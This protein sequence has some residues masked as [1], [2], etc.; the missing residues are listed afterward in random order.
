MKIVKGLASLVLLLVLVIGIPAVLVLIVGNPLPSGETLQN[1]LTTPDYGGRF[2]FGSFL[3]IVAWIAWLTFAASVIVEIPSAVGGI[4]AP[5]IK[6]LGAQQ[7]L[8]GALIGAILLMFT[9]GSLISA[10]KAQATAP[11][12]SATQISAP[13]S[14]E[15]NTQ[16][17]APA[18]NQAPEQTKA[19]PK[20]TVVAG[21]SLWLLAETYLGDGA[22]YGEIAELNYGVAQADGG[23]LSDGHWIEPGWVL[24]LPASAQAVEKQAMTHVVAEGESLSSIAEH[25]Y[26]DAG[27]FEQ[28]F[29][30]SQGVAQP[31]GGSLTDPDVVLPGWV[32]TVPAAAVVAPTSLA[33]AAT[34]PAV[35]AEVPPP[36]AAPAPAVEAPT[37]PAPAVETPA[38]TAPS[39]EAPAPAVEPTPAAASPIPGASLSNVPVA[40]DEAET[41]EETPVDSAAEAEFPVRTIGG[42]GALLASGLLSV[43]G[44]RRIAQRRRRRA[45][46]RVAAPSREDENLELQLRAVEEPKTIDDLDRAL[47]FLAVWGQDNSIALPQMFC[48]RVAADEIAI[49]LAAPAQLPSPFVAVDDSNTVWTIEPATIGDLDREPTAPYPALVTVGQDAKDAHLLIDLEYVGALGIAG[50]E[51]LVSNALTALAVELA[52]SKWGEQLQVTMVGVSDELPAALSTGKV[53]HVDDMDALLVLLR[54]KAK[55]TKEAFARLGVSGVEEARTLGRDAEGWMPEIVILGQQPSASQRTELEELVTAIPRIGIAAVSAGKVTGDWEIRIGSKG[56]ATLEPLGL[57]MVPQLITDEE[58]K[59]IMS[60]LSVA[61]QD[62]QP[63]PDW[64][65]SSTQDDIAVEDVPVAAAEAA[66]EERKLYALPPEDAPAAEPVPEVQEE[67]PVPSELVALIDQID[68]AVEG[69][70]APIIAVLGTVSIINPQGEAPRTPGS[71]SVSAAAVAR[72]TALAAFLALNPGA[73]METYHEAFWPT[74]DPNGKTA[75]SNRNKLSNLTRNYL[76]QRATDGEMYFPHVGP[77]DGY[78]LHP[79]VTT[80][81]RVFLDLIGEDL[82]RTSTPRLVAALRLVRGRPFSGVKDQLYTWS[83]HVIDGMLSGICDAAHELARR[84]L[85]TGDTANARLAGSVGRIVDPANEQMWRDAILAEHAAGNSAG[86][87]ELVSKLHTY[88]DGFNEDYEPDEETQE[89]IKELRRHGHPIAS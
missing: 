58:G 67:E 80:D 29:K 76:G 37:A 27:A 77:A 4:R 65:A 52:T 5:R 60:L 15:A 64:A 55:A 61:S 2:L 24:N 75:S 71:G 66:Q 36:A 56:S 49:Y 53:R 8:A 19:L 86:V 9:A 51:E 78:K 18:L 39:V 72:C 41:V 21:E 46:E 62:C 89:L 43:L 44:L 11:E 10:P 73:S 20:H 16:N 47:K 79:D 28:I 1:L 70:G 74:A 6:G 82:A 63:G 83:E 34:P 85:T 7:A 59:K 50:E 48:V 30:A 35:A 69:D 33:Q 32:L 3:P 14:V 40:A 12:P 42:I 87:E 57:E 84:S 81:W 38:P 22:R 68:P 25:Y 23:A 31:G 88:L 54:G 26:G 13:V 17:K 45:G